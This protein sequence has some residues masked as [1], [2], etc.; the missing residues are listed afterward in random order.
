MGQ[1][2]DHRSPDHLSTLGLIMKEQSQVI[3]A[4]S[5]LPMK[6]VVNGTN[7]LFPEDDKRPLSVFNVKYVADF[8]KHFSMNQNNRKF[9]LTR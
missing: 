2:W 6:C 7:R 9:A 5:V 3:N 8:S 1:T 4:I